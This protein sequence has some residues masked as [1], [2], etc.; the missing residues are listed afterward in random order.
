MK[1][2]L[3]RYRTVTGVPSVVARW[4][5]S[6]LRALLLAGTGT[7][8]GELAADGSFLVDLPAQVLGAG[9]RRPAREG[10]PAQ[11]HPHP[12]RPDR[13]DR[14]VV[15]V[16]ADDLGHH[17]DDITPGRWMPCVYVS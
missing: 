16:R 10:V 13:R 15:E 7:P 9:D 3:Y 14:R 4:L 6:D 1:R 5:A 11:P 8:A 2:W 17:E 12:G